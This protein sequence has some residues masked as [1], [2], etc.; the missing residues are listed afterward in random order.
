MHK[1]IGVFSS[2]V[3]FSVP[4]ST[5]KH[6]QQES[7]QVNSCIIYV[8]SPTKMYG[9]FINVLLLSSYGDQLRAKAVAYIVLGVSGVYLLG[10]RKLMPCSEILIYFS[11]LLGESLFRNVG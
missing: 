11:Y 3:A 1:A 8:N 10:E 4:S 2:S 9:A 5:T 7:F 6:G